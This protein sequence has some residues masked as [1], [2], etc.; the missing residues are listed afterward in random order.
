VYVCMCLS[1]CV[2]VRVFERVRMCA[3]MHTYVVAK[4]CIQQVQ[5]LAEVCSAPVLFLE[6]AP[7]TSV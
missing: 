6:R 1:V 5:V 3:C 4:C 7:E 2:C